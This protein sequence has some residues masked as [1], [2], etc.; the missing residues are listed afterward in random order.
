MSKYD[1]TS[2]RAAYYEDVPDEK[3][4]NW[5]W[6]LS[7]RINTPEE[8]DKVIK[9][10]ESEREALSAAHLFRV[11]ITPY[12]ASLIDPD[13]TNDPIRKQVVPTAGEKVPFTV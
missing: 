6:Q 12:Y 5:R 11:E 9:L 13:D 8:F 7:N 3:W 10:T 2:K 4:N 1:F